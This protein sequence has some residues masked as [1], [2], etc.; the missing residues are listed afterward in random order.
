MRDFIIGARFVDGGGRQF[1]TGGQVVKNSA[2]FDFPKLFVG[3]LGRLGVLYELSFKVFPAPRS[4]LT[5]N[6]ELGHIER[7]ISAA[8]EIAVRPFDAFAIDIAPPG[9]LRVR[10]GGEA[11]ANEATARRIEMLVPTSPTRQAGE[12]EP[13]RWQAARSFDW[14]TG[15]L[16]V[17]IPCTPQTLSDLDVALG[18][19]DA[20][21]RYSVAGNLAFASLGIDELEA[22]AR[23]LVELRLSGLVLRGEAPGAR[24]GHVPAAPAEALV[25]GALDPDDK[26]LPLP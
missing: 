7:A 20:R 4:Y 13:L 24:V 1:N 21:R 8:Q 10:L 14:A 11:S 18:R 26:F 16:L 3:S 9:T 15:E 23:D 12:S 5:L 22:V 17:K 2:G 19:V 25:K 6:F